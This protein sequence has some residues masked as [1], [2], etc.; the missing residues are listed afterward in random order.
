MSEWHPPQ[1]GDQPPYGQPP[2]GQPP[3]GQPPY[4]Q[5][6]QYPGQQP[7]Q[8]YPHQSTHTYQPPPSDHPVH[9]SIVRAERQSR[10]L[11]GFSIPFFLARYIALI[12]VI[13]VL[14]FVMIAFGVVVWIGQWAILFTGSYPEGMHRF[15][16]G[17]LRW[18]TR[19]GAF[20]YGLTDRYPPFST[21]P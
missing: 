19:A 1:P 21:Q 12:P 15:G 9:L 3:Y 4:G 10:L 7:Y 2:Y 13:F 17:V 14:Y 5:Q 11:A 18:Q 16:T 20:L 6:G 8:A